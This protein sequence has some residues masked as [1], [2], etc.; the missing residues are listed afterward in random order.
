MLRKK[1]PAGGGAIANR[2]AE[3]Q[4]RLGSER[5]RKGIFKPSGL[6]TQGQN[7]LFPLGGR[8]GLPASETGPCAVR[9]R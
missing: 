3:E 1:L 9:K 4:P 5:S 8:C 6:L 2:I 7:Q